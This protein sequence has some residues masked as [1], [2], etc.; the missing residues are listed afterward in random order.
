[1][2]RYH[3]KYSFDTFSHEKSILRQTSLFDAPL[4]YPPYST[5]KLSWF[6]RL[7]GG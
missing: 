4:R 7:M 2:G 6:K 1:M 5:N 3:G